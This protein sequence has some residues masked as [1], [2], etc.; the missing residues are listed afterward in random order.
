MRH[1]CTDFCSSALIADV[2]LCWAVVSISAGLAFDPRA[3][4][5]NAWMNRFL[6]TADIWETWSFADAKPQLMPDVLNGK[7]LSAMHL[8]HAC[9]DLPTLLSLAFP[10]SSIND[11]TGWF[12]PP[13]PSPSIGV[14][15]VGPCGRFISSGRHMASKHSKSLSF[16]WRKIDQEVQVE[17]F[18]GLKVI[19]FSF[20]AT[21]M[22]SNHVL[23]WW[24]PTSWAD[25]PQR[26]A[27]T[28][29]R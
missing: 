14:G 1:F 20:V 28:Y 13:P 18:Q 26:P 4:Y 22:S 7:L 19:A 2:A 6:S 24:R 21:R 3:A 5:Q 23:S 27:S 11:S 29:W 16:D 15:I 25:R 9:L 12:C 10:H 8:L 17:G